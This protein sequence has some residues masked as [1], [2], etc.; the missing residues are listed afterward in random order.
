MN[1]KEGTTL[2]FHKQKKSLVSII[3]LVYNAPKLTLKTLYTLKKTKNI[4]YEVVVL[5]N[6][7]GIITKILLKLMYKL[8]FI[9]KLVTSSEN[10]Y[11]AGGN[12]LASSFCNRE[13]K[14]LL[15]LNSD[16]KILNPNWLDMLVKTHKYGITSIGVCDVDKKIA[17]CDGYCML[18]DKELYDEYKLDENFKWWYGITKLQTEIMA[19][20]GCSVRGCIDDSTL[21]KHYWGGSGKAYK[22]VL[23]VL[24]EE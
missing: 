23:N 22:K 21:I 2:L 1:S 17:R 10:T 15:L 11:F 7:S 5:D 20:V 3:I 12:N 6:A 16:I 19:K 24:P 8:N 13:S 18:I 4:D 9:D 14:Y